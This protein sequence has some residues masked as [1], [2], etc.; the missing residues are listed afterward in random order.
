MDQQAKRKEH[1]F[2]LS[3]FSFLQLYDHLDVPI[4]TVRLDCSSRLFV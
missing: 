3:R 2:R 4:Q 1:H